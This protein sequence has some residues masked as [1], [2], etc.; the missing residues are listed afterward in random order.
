MTT[1]DHSDLAADLRTLIQNFEAASEVETGDPEAD[2]AYAAGAHGVLDELKA[3][4]N[5]ERPMEEEDFNYESSR[6]FIPAG[7]KL[8]AVA[9]NAIH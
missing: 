9:S 1:I 6:P 3:L 4:L 8:H 2:A 7:F 5:G